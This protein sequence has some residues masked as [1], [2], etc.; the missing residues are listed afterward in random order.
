MRD[1]EVVVG[2]RRRRDGGGGELPQVAHAA[3]RHEEVEEQRVRRRAMT[4]RCRRWRAPS[5]SAFPRAGASRRRTGGARHCRRRRRR[6]RR[7]PCRPRRRGGRGAAAAWRRRRGTTCEPSCRARSR[8]AQTGAPGGRRGS[9]CRRG[10]RRS[11]GRTRT[12]LNLPNAACARARPLIASHS[13]LLACSARERRGGCRREHV[14]RRPRR[15]AR[16]PQPHRK[17]VGAAEQSVRE[18]RR[19]RLSVAR[20]GRSSNAPPRRGACGSVRRAPA[21]RVARSSQT[22]TAPSAHEDASTPGCSGQKA[23]ALQPPADNGPAMTSLLI[24]HPFEPALA[25]GR[26]R[27]RR[28]ELPSGAQSTQKS[29]TSNSFSDPLP[30][31]KLIRRSSTPVADVPD[32]VVHATSTSRSAFVTTDFGAHTSG[33]QHAHVLSD[34]LL[35]ERVRRR[36]PEPQT[37]LLYV[38]G[39]RR[40]PVGIRGRACRDQDIAGDVEPRS[41]SR[42]RVGGASN[43]EQSEGRGRDVRIG[44]RS[45]VWSGGRSGG[46]SGGAVGGRA[47]Y[48]SGLERAEEARLAGDEDCSIPS[49]A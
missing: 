27:R 43:P 1:F 12:S 15:R 16:V 10:A 30:V 32:T 6:R 22:R 19:P 33:G 26:A 21:A 17:V 3:R 9:R 37:L 34:H 4:M 44:V 5:P 20:R 18:Q 13:S 7:A 42:T 11:R 49:G 8:A 31:V 40:Q 29:G 48:R 39:A 24:F 35:L 28:V 38:E 14:C 47:S 46:R 25:R 2:A 23:L 36:P 45:G 41:C